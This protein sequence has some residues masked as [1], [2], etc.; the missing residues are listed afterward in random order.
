MGATI[1]IAGTKYTVCGDGAK[2]EITCY[3]D[4]EITSLTANTVDGYTAKVTN[5][6]V[7]DNQ[8]TYS[9]TYTNKTYGMQFPLK[10]QLLSLKIQDLFLK[11]NGQ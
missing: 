11:E 9:V 5:S 2:S 3:E 6:V 4:D 10:T 8:I 7:G 1:E